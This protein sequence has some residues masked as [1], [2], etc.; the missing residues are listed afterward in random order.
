M[1]TY[2]ARVFESG[3]CILRFSPSHTW[4]FRKPTIK[5]AAKLLA[6]RFSGV[7]AQKTVRPISRNDYHELAVIRLVLFPFSETR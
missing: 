4:L 7:A 2:A 3:R 6:K 5:A 1:E